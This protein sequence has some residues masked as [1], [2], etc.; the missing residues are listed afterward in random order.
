MTRA[1][2]LLIL[3]KEKGNF[4][5][6][7]F[8]LFIPNNKL[9]GRSIFCFAF[10]ALFVLKIRSKTNKRFFKKSYINFIALYAVTLNSLEIIIMISINPNFI[11]DSHQ[12]N[13]LSVCLQ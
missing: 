7:L 2:S 11:T 10:L 13:R 5:A 12:Y 1:E 9:N 4:I 3:K 8:Q 6:I